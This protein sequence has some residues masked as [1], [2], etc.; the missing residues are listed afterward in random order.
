MRKIACSAV[1]LGGRTLNP[2]KNPTAS[3]H[4]VAAGASIYFK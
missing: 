1:R 2:V 4:G 3:A